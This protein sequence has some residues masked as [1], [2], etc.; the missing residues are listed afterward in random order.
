M[1]N[2]LDRLSSAYEREVREKSRVESEIVRNRESVEKVRRN[3]MLYE[4]GCGLENISD[5]SLCKL[6]EMMLSRLDAVK[7]CK[8]KKRLGLR[9]E[10]MKK[11]LL[12]KMPLHEVN[13]LLNFQ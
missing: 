12:K 5:E 4:Q 7:D 13:D 8:A 2:E 11:E 1:V 6:E 10:S 3:V 9:I